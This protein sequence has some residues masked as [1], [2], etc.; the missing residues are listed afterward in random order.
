MEIEIKYK[1]PTITE[2][3]SNLRALMLYE[4]NSAFDSEKY[5]PLQPTDIYTMTVIKTIRKIIA[6]QLLIKRLEI[7]NQV[8]K[9][10]EAARK[11]YPQY[12][13]NELKEK[14]GGINIKFVEENKSTD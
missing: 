1:L 12:T 10:L 14:I 5:L 11:I 6:G 13:I 3:D 7:E 9:A 4:L 2:E 8:N